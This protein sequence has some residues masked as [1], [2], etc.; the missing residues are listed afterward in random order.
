MLHLA[1]KNSVR[2]ILII[3][4]L[5]YVDASVA[6]FVIMPIVVLLN[7]VAPSLEQSTMSRGSK[8]GS[9]TEGEGSVQLTSWY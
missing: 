9:L 1:N 8:Q 6:L 4:T 5:K 3:T 2:T 7:V